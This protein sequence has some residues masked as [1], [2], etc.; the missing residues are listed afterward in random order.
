MN[1]LYHTL[2]ECEHSQETPSFEVKHITL[3]HRSEMAFAVSLY[4]FSLKKCKK[5]N[6]IRSASV[7]KDECKVSPKTLRY[8]HIVFQK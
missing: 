2:S 5:L 3:Y 4:G 6:K 8:I 7:T 1:V